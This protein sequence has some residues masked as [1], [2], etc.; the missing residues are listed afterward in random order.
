M[1][2]AN[3]DDVAFAKQ[4]FLN[5][6]FVDERTVAAAEVADEN[7][8]ADAEDFT[9]LARNAL[10]ENLDI[11]ARVAANVAF[12]LTNGEDAAFLFAILDANLGHAARFSCEVLSSD[13]YQRVV[14]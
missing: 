3:A 9:V 12:L 7:H 2:G 4:F 6:F 1:R 10:V 13:V 11:T 14:P 5:A 8:F